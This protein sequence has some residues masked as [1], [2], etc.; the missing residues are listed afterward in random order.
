MLKKEIEKTTNKWKDIMC[1]WV[2]RINI[3]KL[4]VL[5]KAIYRFNAISLKIPNSFFHRTRTNNSKILWKQ[6]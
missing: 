4:T 1:S 6:E 3:F 2:G 5:P